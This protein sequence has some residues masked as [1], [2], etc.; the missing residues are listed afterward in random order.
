[1]ESTGIYWI[2][3][4]E[5]LSEKGFEVRLV[6]PRSIKHAPGRKSDVVDC[7]WIQQLHSY[8][9]LTSAFCSDDQIAV[10]LAYHRQ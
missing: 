10:L 2:S 6:N 4:F 9:F 8:G 5:I 7:Q 3:L 1:M